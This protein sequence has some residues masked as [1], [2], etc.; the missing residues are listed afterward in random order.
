MKSFLLIPALLLSTVPAVA[1]PQIEAQQGLKLWPQRT[2]GYKTDSFKIYGNVLE[3]G[4][5]EAKCTLRFTDDFLPVVDAEYPSHKELAEDLV[6]SFNRFQQTA[7]PFQND[8]CQGWESEEG[9]AFCS[10]GYKKETFHRIHF[11]F[12]GVAN[13]TP[14]ALICD[15]ESRNPVTVDN[16]WREVSETNTYI[17]H[18]EFKQ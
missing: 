4:Q 18:L 6:V 13:K 15:G 11:E 10:G 1:Q 16:A 9:R 14:V 7:T 17:E 2:G 12:L 5:I 8:V 3:D